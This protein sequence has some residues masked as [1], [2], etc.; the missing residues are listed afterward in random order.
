MPFQVSDT[1]VAETAHT[2]A[3]LGKFDNPD[4]DWTKI[5]DLAER[6]RI[7]NRIAQR[8]YRKKL[9]RKAENTATCIS[10]N[11][12]KSNP[13]SPTKMQKRRPSVGFIKQPNCSSQLHA[14]N[15][16]RL[17]QF[18]LDFC[19]SSS[20]GATP[21]WIN[22]VDSSFDHPIN[23][24]SGHGQLLDST[25]SAP[26]PHDLIA[27]V[28]ATLHSTNHFDDRAEQT[29]DACCGLCSRFTDTSCSP[30]FSIST[31]DS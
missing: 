5:S 30:P 27:A 6:R 18:P 29:F 17:Q 24:S 20:A 12:L 23:P 11:R 26:Y 22:P 16:Y 25:A 21:I 15:E 1:D 13:K 3:T 7:Q 4:E 8:N 14:D 31:Q 2:R 28:P 10:P 19:E 9:K